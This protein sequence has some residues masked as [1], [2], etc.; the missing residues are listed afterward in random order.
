M[1]PEEIFE[2]LEILVEKLPFNLPNH[3]DGGHV[4]PFAWNSYANGEFNIFNLFKINNWIKP[5]DVNS[6]IKEWLEF[7]YA[8]E[9]SPVILSD[10]E[11][12]H[13]QDG[14]KTLSN[15]L[16]SLINLQAYSFRLQEH[17]SASGIIIGQTT[18]G[19]WVGITSTV[20]V[21]SFIGKEVIDFSTF[22]E[23]RLKIDKRKL[24]PDL[25][26]KAVSSL[27]PQAPKQKISKQMK[28]TELASKSGLLSQIGTIILNL[29]DNTEVQNSGDDGYPM[30]LVYKIVYGTGKTIEMA[31][32]KTLQ[33]SHML[34]IGKFNTIYHGDDELYERYCDY[35]QEEIDDIFGKYK[36]ITELINQESI[37]PLVYRISSW[38]IEN[39]YILGAD[40]E[41]DKGNRVG[42]Y[43]K[44]TFVYN[45]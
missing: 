42:V 13:W 9:F 1:H 6:V 24:A 18:D 22:N 27:M 43:I 3:E 8:Q 5:T 39:I 33:A 17:R 29:K 19:D 32:E 20:Y 2:R 12:E 30:S 34:E 35:E 37:D 7:K 26:Q 4:Y 28:Y 40:N 31:W 16:N 44:S 38:D 25:N 11:T 23:S 21:A 45:P 10:R 36:Q 14:I 41:G 15:V